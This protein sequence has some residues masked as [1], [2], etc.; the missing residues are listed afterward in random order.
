METGQLSQLSE[1]WKGQRSHK[2]KS[3]RAHV[4]PPGIQSESVKEKIFSGFLKNFENLKL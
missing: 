2:F 4:A 3:N 1:E